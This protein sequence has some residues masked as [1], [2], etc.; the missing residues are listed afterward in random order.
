M[1]F[2]K[3]SENKIERYEATIQHKVNLFIEESDDY[4]HAYVSFD[5]Y[6]YMT[7]LV[8][9][10]KKYHNTVTDE[11][12]INTKE[13]FLEDIPYYID[14]DAVYYYF[15]DIEKLEAEEE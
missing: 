3:K 9:V 4:F 11:D 13:S 5:G 12:V 10:P 7:Y 15:K 1:T 2:F 8:G 14:D 6:S